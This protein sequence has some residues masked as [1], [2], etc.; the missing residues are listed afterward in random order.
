M[1]PREPIWADLARPLLLRLDQDGRWQR[2]DR[3]TQGLPFPDMRVASAARGGFVQRRRNWLTRRWEI[4][5]SVP[6]WSR[7]KMGLGR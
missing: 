2:E 7:A 4:R 1:T 3:A 6:G 5:L